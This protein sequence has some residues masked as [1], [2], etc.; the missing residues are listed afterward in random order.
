MNKA[1]KILMKEGLNR[2]SRAFFE[3]AEKVKAEK[4]GEKVVYGYGDF[5]EAF[6][7]INEKIRQI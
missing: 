5:R 4:K 7:D 1:E 3:F 2:M 6:D